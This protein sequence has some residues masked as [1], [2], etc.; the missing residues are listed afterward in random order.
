[1]PKAHNPRRGSMAHYPRK[2]VKRET[3]MVKHWPEGGSEPKIQGFAGY[4]AG[5]THAFI[6][7]FRPTSTTSGQ[8][9]MVPVTVV[10]VPPMKVVGIRLYED[11]AYGMTT[12]N[13]VWTDK[14]DKELLRSLPVPEKPEKPDIKGLKHE[15]IDEVRVI[16]HSR[17]FSVKSLPKKKPEIMEM[18]VGGGTMEQRVQYAKGL[19]GKEIDF[20]EFQVEGAMVDIISTT[21]GKGFQGVNKRFG[22][23]LLTHKNS[24]HR[25]MIGTQGPWHPA[26]IMAT[27]PNSGQMGYHKRTEY[28]KRILKVGKDPSEINPKGGFVKY[29]NL[30]NSYVLIHG[31]IPGVTKRLIR[32]RDPVRRKGVEVS[33]PEITYVSTSSKQGK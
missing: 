12:K 14:I 30:N 25:R 27:V 3:P 20:N 2:R 24:K 8:E 15:G 31:S 22:A 21:K 26:W 28:N 16:V 7:D 6:V 4:K 10:E 19:L 11:T 13:E 33:T 1:M 29:G 9:V 18:R 32:F 5:M 17:P 23:K